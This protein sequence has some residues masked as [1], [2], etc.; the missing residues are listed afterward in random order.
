MFR[1]YTFT[2]KIEKSNET[3]LQQVQNTL[4]L[5]HFSPNLPKSG[6]VTLWIVGITVSQKKKKKKKKILMSQSREKLVTEK[7]RKT[8][9][10]E[11]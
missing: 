1:A 3:I 2:Q 8:A 5:G 4:S 9:I 6:F 10:N 11:P 7:N